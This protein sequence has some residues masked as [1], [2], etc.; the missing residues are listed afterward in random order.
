MCNSDGPEEPRVEVLRAEVR[1][2][3]V[4]SEQV[5]LT[6]ARQLDAV[7][8][9]AIEPFGRVRIDQDSTGQ[10]IEVIGSAGGVLVRSATSRKPLRCSRDH[11]GREQC[12]EY[13]R[14][15]QADDAA[16][17]A[18]KDQA[19][20]AGVTPRLPVPGSTPTSRALL[21]HLDHDWWGYTDEK[22]L[23]EAWEKLPLIVLAG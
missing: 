1:V 6:V 14:L 8:P 12:A 7:E 11:L 22:A 3:T 19:R 4:S 16:L 10:M 17:Q 13:K 9:K 5:T 15:R 2:L 18:L 20:Q 21:D 23:Y